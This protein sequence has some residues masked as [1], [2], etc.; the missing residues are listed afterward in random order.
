MLHFLRKSRFIPRLLVLT[1]VYLS[2]YPA[3]NAAMVTT[4]DLVEDQQY[5]I[6]R[7][8][9]LAALERDD[10]KEALIRQGVDPEMAKQRVASMTTAEIQAVNQKM[11][12]LPAGSGVLEVILIVFLV[13]LF[14]DIM[15]WTN[16]FPFVKKTAN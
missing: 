1:M 5:Q 8:R 4:Q 10:V 3:V 11:A 2:A 6:E 9:L 14:T 13:L 15:G 12:S 16:I 7:N